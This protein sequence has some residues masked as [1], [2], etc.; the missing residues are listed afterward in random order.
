MQSV[1]VTRCTVHNG[2]PPGTEVSERSMLNPTL[3]EACAITGRLAAPV[4]AQAPTSG[5]GGF[6][7]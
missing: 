3:G 7:S 5:Q 6:A 2:K 1:D 4:F